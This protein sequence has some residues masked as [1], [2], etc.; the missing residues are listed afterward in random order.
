MAE[1]STPQSPAP[2]PAKPD[3][4]GVKP[5][6][7]RA[8]SLRRP[9]PSWQAIM[10]GLCCVALCLAAWWL[11]TEKFSSDPEARPLVNPLILPSPLATFGTFKELWF[12]NALAREILVTLRR[13][14]VGFLMAVAVGIPIGIAAGC[15][16][17]IYAF[18]MPLIMFGRNIPIAALIPLMVFIVKFDLYYSA[19][20]W[21]KM[22][23]IFIACLAFIIA[24]TARAIM[25]VAERYVDTAYTLGAS[26][27]QTIV[28]VLVPLAMPTIFS[29]CRLMFGI[30]F[31]YI[32]LAE[33]YKESGGVGGLGY[34]IQLAEKR[35]YPDRIY[36]IILIIPIVALLVDQLLAWMQR[37]L[38]PYQ[39]AS[40]GVLNQ[41][42]RWSLHA[43]DDLKRRVVGVP[44]AAQ[45][46]LDQYA[47][48]TPVGSKTTPAPEQKP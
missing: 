44:P 28:Q 10:L 32:M 18:L 29:S 2:V 47:L 21:R 19:P 6:L 35:S 22:F 14:A 26:R 23:F 11:A 33:S 42:V 40:D 3:E 15:F 9:I 4:A 13:V 36:L 34:Q 43:W 16:P 31:G 7:R 41:L 30:A 25:D 45:S 17:R 5:R 12:D 27:W 39:Y 48:A 24:D 37:S 1:P 8:L 46:L 38:F 20:E